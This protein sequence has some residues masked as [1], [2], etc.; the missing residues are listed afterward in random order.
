MDHLG[1]PPHPPWHRARILQDGDHQ[2]DPSGQIEA[3]P[4]GLAHAHVPTG[5]YPMCAL[6]L[7]YGRDES[8]T[9]VR[10]DSDD[11]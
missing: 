6:L 11:A 10:G 7:L 8:G 2:P 9:R 1:P 3:Q 4:S 5:L